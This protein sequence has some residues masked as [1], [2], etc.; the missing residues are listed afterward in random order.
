[1]SAPA[2]PSNIV[3]R[4]LLSVLLLAGAAY[5]FVHRQALLDTFMVW[6]YEPSP[7]IVSITDRASF[8][9]Q[10]TFLFYASHPELL[11]R[12]SFNAACRSNGSERTAILG[13][14]SANRIY[15]YDINNQKL[16]G[17]KEVTAAHEMLHAAYQRLPRIEK[18]RVNQLLKSQELGTHQARVDELM[19]EYAKTEPGEE[20]NELHSIIGSEVRT[21]SPELEAYYAQYFEDRSALVTLAEKYQTV[22]NELRA[23]QDGLAN[24]LNRL[25]DTI[26]T[27]SSVYKRNLQVLENDIEAFNRDASS[28]QMSRP[29]YESGRAALESRQVALRREYNAI[30]AM[31]DEYEQK[32]AELAAINSESDVLNRSINSSL[33]P[34][35]DDING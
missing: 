12:D 18:D 2:Q 30:Q 21:L 5:V 23:R 17:V 15:L 9:E 8:D 14:Y 33:S 11:S 27:T 28:G 25:A 26:E 6:Q 13:C 22:F 3:F 35:P 16:D 20:F 31:L 10:G 32:R 1:M 29:S 24:E 34:V 19:A 4:L 7:A